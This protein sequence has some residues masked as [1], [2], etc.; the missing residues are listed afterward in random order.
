MNIMKDRFLDN[1]KTYLFKNNKNI[2][3]QFRLEELKKNEQLRVLE[4]EEKETV[5]NRAAKKL[6]AEQRR[7]AR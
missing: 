4:A 3:T 2:K 5:E 1:N 7:I 6:V